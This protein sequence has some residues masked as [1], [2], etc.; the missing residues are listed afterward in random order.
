MFA[1]K[2][3]TNL[4]NVNCRKVNLTVAASLW[5]VTVGAPDYVI[6]IYMIQFIHAL[7]AL[8]YWILP[9]KIVPFLPQ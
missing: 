8:F 1:L 5:T 7:S 6:R 9:D 4:Q 3:D 2:F